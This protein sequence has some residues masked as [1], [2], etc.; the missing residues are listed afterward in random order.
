[1][2]KQTLRIGLAGLGRLGRRYAE[3]LARA[4]PRAEL[5]AVSSPVEAERAWASEALG[6]VR[7]YDSFEAM[8]ADEAIDAVFLVTPT[9][10]HATQIE[11]AL[12]AGKHVFCEKPLSLDL[13]D[14]RRVAKHAAKSASR[15][16]VGFV[17]RF[18]ESYRHAAR[19]I[20]A[21]GIGRPFMVYSQT[22]DLADPSG[23]FLEFA[24]TSGGIFLDCS[25][26]DI[27]LARWLLGRPVA[28][29]VYSTGTVAMYPPLEALGDVDNGVA[30]CEFADGRMAMFY[31]SRTQAHGHDTHTDV[32]GTAG[33]VSIGRNPRADRVEISD[34]AGVRNTVVPSFY[35]RFAP[36]FVTQAR[37]FVDAVLDETPFELTIDDAVEA[38]RI[39]VALRESLRSGQPVDL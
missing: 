9:S 29:R 25:V 39:A 37:H 19:H 24:P 38:T 21:G 33:K 1:M 31:A 12:D 28:K 5:V 26:H 3:N 27:D 32:V 15:A 20:E 34:A 4:V 35:E 2:S 7:V 13:D 17:R 14:C 16:M 8:L 36:A 10:L 22:T 23:A 30:I 11:Q 18:D 6:D